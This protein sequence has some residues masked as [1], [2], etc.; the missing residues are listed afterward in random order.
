MPR[1]SHFVPARKFNFTCEKLCALAK[2]AE[3]WKYFYD[4]TVRGL[5]LGVNATGVR[6]FRV[7]RKF[8]PGATQYARPVWIT[9]GSFDPN[10]SESSEENLP[11]GTKPLDLLGHSPSL[12]V[13]MARKLATAV[14]ASLDA[15]VNP[16]GERRPGN[17]L[18]LGEVFAHYFAYLTDDRKRKTVPELKRMFEQY[19]G[20]LPDAPRK[21]HGQKRTKPEGSVNWQR[22]PAAAITPADISRLRLNIAK[23]TGDTTA[24]RVMELIRAA[25]NYAKKKATPPLY[26]G[27]NPAEGIEKFD[28]PE[29]ERFVQS[30][31]A[32][33]FMEALESEKDSDFQDYLM[34]SIA[35]G[36]RRKN[37]LRMRWDELS[38]EGKAWTLSGEKMKNG[39]P[40]VVPLVAKAVEI[41]QGRA[42]RARKAPSDWVFP[43]G[44]P[45]GHIG[46]PRKKWA[47][48]LKR[49]KLTDLHLHDLRRTLGSW[50]TSTGAN[51]VMTMR[52]LAH[53]DIDA[54]LIYQRLEIA[55]VRDAMDRGLDAFLKA[56]NSGKSNIVQMPPQAARR[57]KA[58]KAKGAR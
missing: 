44:T 31:E 33:G 50:M 29:R 25:F 42:E 8:K 12:N 4:S 2:P 45:A 52:A 3:G 57:G 19:V 23:H 34:L 40:I 10:L 7:Y 48:F 55:P 35:T 9:L 22:R 21:K 30:H 51:T 46:P 24:N 15:G 37:L 58:N 39:K 36:A 43:G 14:N 41:L 13:R 18:T 5:V 1:K 32:T 26:T 20:E 47:K 38:L 53:R 11:I 28:E 17:G 16:A 49:A 56:A 27:E 6:S 54:A